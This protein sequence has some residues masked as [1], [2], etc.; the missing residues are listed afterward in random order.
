MTID[1]WQEKLKQCQ[2]VFIISD[3]EGSIGNVYIDRESAQ[4]EIDWYKERHATLFIIESYVQTR[5]I[6]KARWVDGFDG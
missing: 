6:S 3:I 1:E 2:R 5:E 4:L